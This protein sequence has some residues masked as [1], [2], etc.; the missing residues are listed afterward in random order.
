MK[1]SSRGNGRKG[2]EGKSRGGGGAEKEVWF[3]DIPL[4]C[5]DGDLVPKPPEHET[6]SVSLVAGNDKR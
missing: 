1:S 6:R 5:V 3:D 4:E 2:A